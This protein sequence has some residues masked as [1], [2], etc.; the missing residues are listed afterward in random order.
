MAAKRLL[1]V[2]SKFSFKPSLIATLRANRG[3][4]AFKRLEYLGTNNF[5][6]TY[7]DHQDIL[8]SH[9][10]WLR[11]RMNDTSTTFQ[12]K[13]RV[14][15]NFMRSTFEETTDQKMIADLIRHHLPQF[16][17]EEHSFGLGILARFTTT[18]QDFR[19]NEKFAVVL[20]YTD[21]GHS[22]G[23][24]ELMAENEAEAEAHQEI[25]DFMARYPWFFMKGK[26]MGK[27]EAYLLQNRRK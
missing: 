24:V 27:L 25:D 5:T 14:S 22:V 16:N 3:N 9:G 7:Y 8:S 26:P 11:Q 17:A 19:A 13:I 21:F 6:D 4:P 23:E 1:E 10:I 18:R 2:E 20:D 12:A 15:G